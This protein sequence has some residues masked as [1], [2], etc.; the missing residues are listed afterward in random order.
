MMKFTA[1]VIVT[2]LL[3]AIIGGGYV[4]LN[5]KPKFAKPVPQ[6]TVQSP[7]PTAFV[8]SDKTATAS[9]MSFEQA[10]V[11]FVNPSATIDAI[12]TALTNKLYG[13]LGS[14]MTATVLV[15][16]A[17][18]S[19]IVTKTQATQRLTILNQ[20][21]Q[22]WDLSSTNPIAAELIAADPIH[23]KNAFIGTTNNYYAAAFTLNE[24][25]LINKIFITK[26]YHTIIS[27]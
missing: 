23:F 13:N 5:S 1:G 22:P 3:V 15:N 12:T 11:G 25:Y 20:A 2:L 7:S 18:S 21:R 10:P 14:Y 8:P 9:S 27:K 4:A 6:S 24:T 17:G 19:G 16:I 26:N